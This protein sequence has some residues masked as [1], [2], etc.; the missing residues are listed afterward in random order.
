MTWDDEGF[1]ISKNKYS[2]NS[3]IVEIFTKNHGKTSGIIF[4]GTS[5][6]IKNYLQL[7]NQL[8]VN[9]S[10]KTENK[11]GNFKIELLKAYAPIF[12]NNYRKLL[13][14]FSAFQ[15][16]KIL[17]AESQKNIKI[18]GLIENFYILL[19]KENWIRNYIFWELE[20]F[21]IIGYDLE[22][23]NL[24]K[25]ELINNEVKY[26]V[27]STKEKK[28]VPNF[29]IDNNQDFLNEEILIDGLR[30]VGDYLEKSILRPNNI[31]Y[32]LSRLRFLNTFK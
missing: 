19:K 24:V 6:K 32:P 7:G 11:I 23:K 14:I 1:L 20:L 31:N 5:R 12:F 27:K 8:Q 17:T 22:L 30:L 13:C 25:K 10:S 16:I 2:E 28:I 3:L 4:G 29:L 15:L 26:L 9:Y 21:K 18:Y